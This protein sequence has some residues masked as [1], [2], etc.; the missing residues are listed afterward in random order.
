LPA[1]RAQRRR[2][3]KSSAKPDD[4]ASFAMRARLELGGARAA[5]VPVSC[6]GRV[7]VGGTDVLAAGLNWER[8]E[9]SQK[10]GGG[11]DKEE[12][13]KKK[14]ANGMEERRE[15]GQ[16]SFRIRGLTRLT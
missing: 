1:L 3:R 9:S 5:Q 4:D 11:T 7:G 15:R 10:Q 13:G 12:L 14:Q 2:R 16:C 8:R 6:T